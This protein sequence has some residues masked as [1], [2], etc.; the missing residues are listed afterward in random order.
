MP[1]NQ[2]DAILSVIHVNDNEVE[3]AKGQ[4]GYD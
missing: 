2:F 1:V 3:V 4:P